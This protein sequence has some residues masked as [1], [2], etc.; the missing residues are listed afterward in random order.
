MKYIKIFLAMSEKDMGT[1]FNELSDYIRSLNDLYIGRSIFFELCMPGETDADNIDDSQYFFLL[2]YRDAD[3]KIVEDFDIALKKFNDSG[4]P[5]IV[6]YFKI[7]EENSISEGV[8]SF[9]ERLEKGMEHFYNKFDNVDTV[10][11]SMLLEMARNQET[12]L[13]IEFK[14][15]KVLADKKEVGDISLDN[16]PQYFNNEMLNKLREERLRLEEEYIRLQDISIRKKDDKKLYEKLNDIK[17][18]KIKVDKRFHEIEMDVLN[19]TSNIV[20][21]TTDGKRLT[22]RAKK[23]LEYSNAGDYENCKDV[24]DDEERRRAWKRVDEKVAVIDEECE[25]LINEIRVKVDTIKAQGINNESEKEIIELYEEAKEKIFKYGLDLEIVVDYAEFL[26]RRKRF[27]DGIKMGE[28][29]YK[30]FKLKGLTKEYEDYIN[31]INVLSLLGR[32]YYFTRQY[33]KAEEKYREL[34]DIWMES[35]LDGVNVD[36]GMYARLYSCDIESLIYKAQKQYKESESKLLEALKMWEELSGH[37]RLYVQNV[38]ISCIKLGDLYSNMNKHKEAEENYQRALNIYI[39]LNKNNPNE[40]IGCMV[41]AYNSIGRLYVDMRKYKEAEEKCQEAMEI[42]RE[43]SKTNRNVYIDNVAKINN[44]LGN[45]YVDIG[46]YRAA[47]E[48]YKEALKIY[49]ELSQGNRS[50][51]LFDVAGINNNLGNL[52]VDIG[53]YRAAEEKYKEALKIYE[54]LSQG[55]RSAYLFDVAGIN[56]NLG[57]LYV[58]IGDY[59]AAEEKYKEA[60]NIYRNLSRGKESAYMEEKIATVCNMLGDLYYCTGQYEKAEK[61]WLETLDIYRKIKQSKK[62]YYDNNEE[63]NYNG[64]EFLNEETYQSKYLSDVAAVCTSL[65]DLYSK[66]GLD[67]KAE[68][69]YV[70]AHVI[71]SELSKEDN[72]YMEMVAV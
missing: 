45:L 5:K 35:I 55:N 60:L 68:E 11:L 17:I 33:K 27:Y 40:Y 6:T 70:E 36:I 66:S 15:G 46:D 58:D 38:A 72:S 44:N 53:D 39:E 37:S 62:V 16:I 1:E 30:Y 8:R 3:E 21:L 7:T 28:E 26:L 2:F 14:D 22:A 50:A 64:M 29:I 18:K 54:E 59:R 69:K 4:T 13:D 61:K 71:Y 10:K 9:M 43:L 42:G 32:L 56:N 49:E 67:I 63:S 51:Y 24:L 47:E 20:E 25:G 12:K 19:M 34:L 31:Y 48:K 65:G 23:A 52:Y 41:S 57:N